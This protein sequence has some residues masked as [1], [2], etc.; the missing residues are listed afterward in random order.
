MWSDLLLLWMARGPF[1]LDFHILGTWANTKLVSMW[2]VPPFSL[3]PC[4]WDKDETPTKWYHNVRSIAPFVYNNNGRPRLGQTTRR[5]QN[6]RDYRAHIHTWHT[7]C[8]AAVCSG[9]H[10]RAGE[11]YYLSRKS[12]W[13]S[14]VALFMMPAPDVQLVN[15]F[16]RLSW[17]DSFSPARKKKKK[18]RVILYFA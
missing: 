13:G 7:R 4:F 1:F 8:N 6:K 12:W 17:L 11:N 5:R 9:I 15:I 16:F 2:G 10:R 14:L 3:A 18:M